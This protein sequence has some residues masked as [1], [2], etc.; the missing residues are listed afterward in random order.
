[1]SKRRLVLLA[2]ICSGVVTVSGFKL[3]APD[4]INVKNGRSLVRG[5]TRADAENILGSS[6]TLIRRSDDL[7]RPKKLREEP[8][9]IAAPRRDAIFV[10]PYGSPVPANESGDQPGSIHVPNFD[11]ISGDEYAVLWGCPGQYFR[12]YF[13][14]NDQVVGIEGSIEDSPPPLAKQVREFWWKITGE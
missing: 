14:K 10:R 7:D 13:D 11:R 1:M 2:V 12:L 3:F 6:G 8:P 5:M 9:P 4:P